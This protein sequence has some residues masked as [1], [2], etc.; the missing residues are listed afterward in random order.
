MTDIFDNTILCKNC[1]KKMSN[2]S[3]EKNNFKLRLVECKK[4][5]NKIIHPQDLKEYEDFTNLRKKH[6]KV[7]LRF[8]GNSYAVSIPREIVNFMNEQDRQMKQ[9]V[10]LCLEEF[11]KISLNF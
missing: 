9:M 2:A 8:V 3:I 5:G 4:C 11:D 1:N 7:K 6:Y 10:N